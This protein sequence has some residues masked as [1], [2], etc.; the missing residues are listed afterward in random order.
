VDVR[1]LGSLEVA[2]NGRPVE[3]GRPKQRAVLAILA[4]DANR[5]VALDRLVDELWGDEPPAHA[6]G[7]LQAYVSH[8]RRLL[9]PG[10][11]ARAPARVLVS[12]HPGYRL[13]LS[14]EELDVTRFEAL[15]ADG[16]RQ[17]AAGEAG[18]AAG[19][20]RRALAVWRGD[21]LADFADAEFA[22]AERV[23]LAAA[24]LGALEDRITADLTLGRHAAVVTELDRAVAA[25]PYRESLHGLRMLALYR[26]GR[27]AEALDAYRRLRR[28]LRDE[29][30]VDPDPRLE[31]LHRQILDHAPAVAVP[32]AAV[33]PTAAPSTVSGPSVVSAP[34]ALPGPAPSADADPFVG[35]APELAVLERALADAS[36]GRGR[37][38]VLAGE[39]GVG[40]TRLARELA[41]R[42]TGA[43]VA[44]GRCAEEPGA[45][46][47]WPWAQVLRGLLGG[48]SAPPDLDEILGEPPAPA[49]PVVDVEAVRFRLGRAVVG[50]LR[51]LAVDRP[52]LVI[53]DDVQWADVGSLRL[54]PMLAADLDGARILVVV[55]CRATGEDRADALAD[56][57]AA[58]ARLPAVDRIRLAA[59]DRADVRRLVA[60]RLGPGAGAGPDDRLD[61][62]ADD[63]HDRSGGNPF[64]AV[65]LVRLLATRRGTDEVP[66]GVRD[67]LRR[68]LARLPEQTRAVLLLAAVVG[69]E[70][71]LD[72]VRDA[73]GLSDGA[74]LDAVEAGLMAGLVSENPADASGRF[75]FEHDLVRE[76]IYHD[77]SRARRARLH[78]RVAEAL[79]G[80][81]DRAGVHWWLAAPAV[82]SAT[83][84]PR[85]LAAAEHATAG[86]DHETAER[87]LR[88][89]LTLITA[90]PGSTDRVRAELDVQ[91]R[92][93]TLYAQLHGAQSV[94]ARAAATRARELAEDLADGPATVAAH[95]SLY[96]IAVARAEH[97][98]AEN[99]AGQ[100]LEVSGRLDDP[101]LL[102]V[103]HLAVARTSWC[104][105][106]P[107]TAREHLDR[108]LALA[109]TA[110][111]QPHEVLPVDVTMRLQ[112]AP[113][114]DL[115]GRPDEAAA[116]VAAAVER[117]RDLPALVRAGVF[118]SA[119]LIG[120]LRRDVA[121]AGA[122]ADR[123]LDLAGQLPAWFSYASAVRSW[124]RA[125]NGDPA[126]G[127]R[128]LR[129]SLAAI[130]SRGAGHLVPWALALLAEAETLA[131][132]PAEALRLLD[133]ALDLV[134]R[135]GERMCEAELHRLRGAALAAPSCAD[136]SPETPS[137]AAAAALRTAVDVARR[138]GA[139]LLASRAAGDLAR[140]VP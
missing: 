1:I 70:F 31:Q 72:V 85:L 136:A 2:V 29:L 43:A 74:A 94:D 35:R 59:L 39:P 36:A 112:L 62:I 37:M 11:A 16:R 95:R 13:V 32:A 41:Q 65:E 26:C 33:P 138:Q 122:H 82:G 14:P 6:I 56:A 75:R 47:F 104:R 77:V 111:D 81:P 23:R 66:A 22:R 79:H 76:A 4:L 98:V 63:V 107:A 51:P 15:A 78:A 130:R 140:L 118:T 60:A 8:L 9:E 34:S 61:R 127:A 115:L 27:Q 58:L 97:A 40:K 117:T 24:R 49:P 123:A 25:H 109:A 86:I 119:A 134:E 91:M 105:G 69:R 120:A 133:D 101:A 46:P 20:L 3:L 18:A 125:M 28:S 124:V 50:L 48:V 89:A 129:T 30:G 106:D 57:L 5:T 42:A 126:D 108:G 10:R 92:L 52:L 64:F 80:R 121:A 99:L 17:L 44:W 53:V 55:T 84:V 102:A 113:V 110:P 67:V 88:H 114:L 7:S 87:H 19:T 38:V 132:R 45:P 135:T 54:L 128:G 103:A 73:S 21:L 116:Q 93:G 83:A 90:E 71:D 96:E 12:Q 68:R 100:L 131:G 139:V 137:L